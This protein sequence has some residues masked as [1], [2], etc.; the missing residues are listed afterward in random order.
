MEPT[1]PTPQP[2]PASGA[3]PIALSDAQR[4]ALTEARQRRRKI[5]RAIGVA[6]FNGWCTAVFAVCSL[7]FVLLGWPAVFVTLVLGGVAY[8]E[9]KG[10][11]MLRELDPRGCRV[12]G[13]NQLGFLTGLIAYA[14]W[15]IVAALTQPNPYA[16]QMAMYPELT[17]TLGD[18]GDLYVVLSI[19]IYG[20][21]IV[22]SLGFQG[23][24][25]IYYFTRAKHVRAYVEKTPEWVI[26]A[27]RS[28]LAA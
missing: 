1:P 25:A 8:F 24:M 3:E 21:L 12:L 16:E 14:T 27:Q 5:D 10:R 6:S 22:G 26:E 2:Q 4:A 17:D 11:N 15:R 20:A 13:L 19:V 9:F 23:G 28:A 7:P 18:V